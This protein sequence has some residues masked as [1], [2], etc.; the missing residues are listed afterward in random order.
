MKCIFKNSLNGKFCYEY[1]ILVQK[2][3]TL[4]KLAFMSDYVYIFKYICR[5]GIKKLAILSLVV[6]IFYTY[7]ISPLP[8]NTFGLQF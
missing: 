2:K 6:Y 4:N 1:F 7:K 8:I 5:I 3:S